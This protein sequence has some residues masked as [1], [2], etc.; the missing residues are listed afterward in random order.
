MYSSRR[1]APAGWMT[2][3]ECL[4]AIGLVLLVAALLLETAC[5][6]SIGYENVWVERKIHNRM[7][8]DSLVEERTK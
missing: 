6:V 1:R 4:T 5:C 8:V 3:Q 7:A 2:K